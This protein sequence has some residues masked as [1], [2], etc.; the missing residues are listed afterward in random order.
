MDITSAL[1]KMLPENQVSEVSDLI[2]SMI[3]A[4]AEEIRNESQAKLDE[5]FEEL[6]QELEAAKAKAN[7]GYE[8]AY[9]IINSLMN[10]I[11]EQREE[12]EATL[13]NGFEEAHAENEKLIAKNN[14][15]ELELYDEFNNKLQEMGNV[16][17]EKVDQFL[18]LQEVEMYE[19]AKRD[20]LN[21]P[22]VLEQK[23]AVE[24]M[25][26]I[27]SDYI[28]NDTVANVTTAKVEESRRQVEEL[29]AQ[30]R[31]VE[32]KNVKLSAKNNQLSEQVND[33]QGIIAEAHKQDRKE[34]AAKKGNVSGR[35]QRVVQE[36][37]IS[38]FNAPATNESS[39]EPTVSEAVDPM[40]ELLVLSGLEQN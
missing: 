21:D 23:I 27:L 15:L 34:R 2:S 33:A 16:M 1:A 18:A 6:T 22:R 4:K 8:Q 7:E 32:A 38:E 29:R 28:S 3:E 13:E 10:R 35:G 19:Q 40:H 37:L 17:V 39:N 11:D 25:A 14:T 9:T 5:A 36:Q 31:I 24:K 20:V 26:E 30:L 12:Y